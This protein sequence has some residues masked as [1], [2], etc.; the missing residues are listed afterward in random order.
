MVTA[1]VQHRVRDYATWRAVFEA[2][3]PELRAAGCCGAQVLRAAE[4][5]NDVTVIVEWPNRERMQA[6]FRAQEGSDAAER[7]GVVGLPT[8]KVL[9]QAQVYRGE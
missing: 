1:I 5:P 7:A 4:D 3:L 9:E 6:F 8:L 2:G